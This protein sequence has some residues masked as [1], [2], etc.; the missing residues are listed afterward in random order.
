MP[1]E[2]TEHRSES[3]SIDAL[4]TAMAWRRGGCD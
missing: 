3:S 1:T 2:M 4:A